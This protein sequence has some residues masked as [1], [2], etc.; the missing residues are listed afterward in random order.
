MRK[1]N[2][3]PYTDTR[4]VVMALRA[5]AVGTPPAITDVWGVLKYRKLCKD[6]AD[7]IDRLVALQMTHEKA[8][9]LLMKQLDMGIVKRQEF[10]NIIRSVYAENGKDVDDIYGTFSNLEGENDDKTNDVSV[11]ASSEQSSK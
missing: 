3:N 11:S 6:S 4:P 8:L 2:I 5:N 1:V 10:L 9:Q 7:V